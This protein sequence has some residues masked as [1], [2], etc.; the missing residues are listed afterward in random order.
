MTDGPL[1]HDL[2]RRIARYL[3]TANTRAKRDRACILL[4]KLAH[5]IVGLEAGET[6][7]EEIRE[8]GK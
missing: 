4:R 5:E 2:R 3:K 8:R 7:V 1:E 6:T